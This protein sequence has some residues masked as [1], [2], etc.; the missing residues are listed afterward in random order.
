MNYLKEFW[1]K[2]KNNETGFKTHFFGNDFYSPEFLSQKKMELD[3][4]FPQEYPAT[5]T[6]A[7]ISSGNP[8]FDLEALKFYMGEILEPINTY[9][10]YYDLQI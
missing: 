1:D 2:S 4:K 7:F 9:A 5:D 8:F 3:D 10:T 6:E